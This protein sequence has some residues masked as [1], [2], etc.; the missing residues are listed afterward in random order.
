LTVSPSTATVAVGSTTALTAISGTTCMTEV[1]VTWGSSW[2]SSDPTVAS[3]AGG[4]VTGVSPGGP[5]A[6]T[7]SFWMLS[8]AASVT[9]VP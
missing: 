7:A 4:G 3:V 8:D 5:V 6:I 9:V 1:D 2:T